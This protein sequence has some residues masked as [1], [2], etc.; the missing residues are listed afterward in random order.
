MRDDLGK[1]RRRHRFLS[2]RTYLKGSQARESEMFAAA[3][4]FH[5]TPIVERLCLFVRRAFAAEL[6]LRMGMKLAAREYLVDT[7]ATSRRMISRFHVLL[8][9]AS[10]VAAVCTWNQLARVGG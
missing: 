1:M 6:V 4:T 8:S 5:I 7:V 9:A 10:L 3:L 2:E